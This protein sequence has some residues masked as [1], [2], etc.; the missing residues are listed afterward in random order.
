[1]SDQVFQLSSLYDSC[2]KLVQEEEQ[3]AKNAK[4]R[5]DQ[6]YD[7]YMGTMAEK[8]ALK[9]VSH[10]LNGKV[11]EIAKVQEFMTVLKHA[12]WLR[13]WYNHDQV[14]KSLLPDTSSATI[15]RKGSPVNTFEKKRESSYF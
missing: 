4:Q 12:S 5:F 8:G 11:I 6:L 14:S 7:Q 3:P 13:S 15:A 9:L 1:M 10:D 2:S